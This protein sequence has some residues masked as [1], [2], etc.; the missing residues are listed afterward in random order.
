VTSFRY[1]VTTDW[2]YDGETGTQREEGWYMGDAA[3]ITYEPGEP[4]HEVIVIGP[5][6]WAR[7][8]SGWFRQDRDF[9]A[10]FALGFSDALAEGM[11][12]PTTEGLEDVGPGPVVDGERTRRYQISTG[13]WDFS[14]ED[15]DERRQSSPWCEQFASA[16]EDFFS[17]GT[18]SILIGAETQ[19]VYEMTFEMEPNYSGAAAESRVRV[20]LDK[21][22]EPF[23]ISPPPGADELPE[24]PTPN[25]PDWGC[26]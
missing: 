26:F 10:S 20:T 21:Y 11:E 12:A 25:L 5:D 16:F 1:I 18:G 6:A 24:R 7:D 23:T 22:E 15:L 8:S 17:E 13:D 3:R 19:R 4:Y 14:D 9:L 2:A